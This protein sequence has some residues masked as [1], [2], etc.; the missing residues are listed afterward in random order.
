MA[1][2]GRRFRERPS[3]MLPIP[4]KPVRVWAEFKSIVSNLMEH[5]MFKGLTVVA[6]ALALCLT[7]PAARAETLKFK[8]VLNGAKMVPVTDSIAT[9][10][11]EFTYDTVT[12]KLEYTVTFKDLTGDINRAALRGPAAP[13]ANAPMQVELTPGPSP[14]KGEETLTDA[15]AADLIAGKW[16]VCLDTAR[17]HLG[18]IRG[19]ITK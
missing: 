19:Q 5:F 3:I 13:T 8:A 1:L 18:E 2:A 12:K 4:G 9:G 6:A 15:Q 17:N 14:I 7:I 16:Y 10:S 11:A